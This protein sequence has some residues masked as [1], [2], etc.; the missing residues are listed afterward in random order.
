MTATNHVLTGA[1]IGVV[2]TNPYFALPVALASHFALDALPHFGMP[3]S[4]FRS[5]RFGVYLVADI[6]L[7][8]IILLSLAIT[9]PIHWQLMLA[10]AVTAASPDLMWLPHYLRALNRQRHKPLIGIERFHSV[11]QWSQTSLGLG[12]EAI[13]F[14]AILYSLGRVLR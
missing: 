1:L 12:L 14:V 4:R 2:I 10:T 7:A 13:W 9:Q 11:I 6:C 8:A 5:V 3:R